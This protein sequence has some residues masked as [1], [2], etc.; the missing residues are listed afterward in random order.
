MLKFLMNFK[1][2][3]TEKSSQK[4]LEILFGKVHLEYRLEYHS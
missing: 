4:K 1:N 2:Q 3:S